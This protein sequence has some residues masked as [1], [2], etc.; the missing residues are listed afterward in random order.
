MISPRLHRVNVNRQKLDAFRN[1]IEFLALLYSIGEDRRNSLDSVSCDTMSAGVAYDDVMTRFRNIFAT[2]KM[3]YV[4]THKF[5]IA[6]KNITNFLLRVEKLCSCL[7]F[8][9][10]DG[11][12]KQFAGVI[13]GNGLRKYFL[14][15]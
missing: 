4:K 3:V 2:N 5:V 9:N 13:A 10:N 1:G 6:E 8:G 14:R 11:V 12:R 7:N 15:T